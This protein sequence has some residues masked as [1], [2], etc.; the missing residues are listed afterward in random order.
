MYNNILF[1]FLIYFN[2]ITIILSILSSDKYHNLISWIEKNGGFV[3]TKVKPLE[4]SSYNR[5]MKSTTEISK[6]ELISFIPEKIVLSSIHPLLNTICHKAYGLHHKS[7]L[8]CIILF[9]SFDKYNLSSFFRPYY[10]FLPE[11][12]ISTFPAEYSQEKLK[13]Y[14]ELEFDLYVGISNNKLKNA[15]N[16]E[17]EKILKGKG[18]SNPY[19]EYKYNFYLVKTRNFARPGSDFL[20][21]LNSCVPFIELFNHDNDFNTDWGFDPKKN[22]FYLR[23][24]KDIKIGEELTTTYGNES[25]INLFNDYGFTLSKNKY[26]NPIR[27]KI[28]NSR[29]SL[30]PSDNEEKNRKDIINLHKS[31][32]ET[33]GFEKNREVFIYK[34]M[35]EGFEKKLEKIKLIKKEDIN[36][37]NIIEEMVLGIKKYIKIINELIYDIDN[38]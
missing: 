6:D 38:I 27:V 3:S 1:S 9:I 13:L 15:F 12:N 17:V 18:I 33:Y 20:F 26:K 29:H 24:V 4:L 19:E 16:D 14:E 37:N 23:A 10:D 25:N 31:L 22:G 30:Y 34:L 28:G 8:E 21:D 2:L 11:L 36:I 32:K 35:I 5:I 7:D